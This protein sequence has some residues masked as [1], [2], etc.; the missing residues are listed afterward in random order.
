[1]SP[2]TIRLAAAESLIDAQKVADAL[3]V[4]LRTVDITAIE[5][6]RSARSPAV[7]VAPGSAQD[8]T[9]RV[10]APPRASLG[11]TVLR[12]LAH[13]GATVVADAEARMLV[14]QDRDARRDGRDTRGL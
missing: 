4:E 1:M 7:V 6:W 8:V 12:L 11:T 5:G 9:V 14:K 10:W 13:Q 2:V 3:R